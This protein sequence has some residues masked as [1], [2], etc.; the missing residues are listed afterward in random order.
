MLIDPRKLTVTI[1]LNETNLSRMVD[2][3]VAIKKLC[4]QLAVDLAEA[5]YAKYPEHRPLGSGSFRI[6]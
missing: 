4:D 2:P 3:G 1:Q 5:Y 6:K